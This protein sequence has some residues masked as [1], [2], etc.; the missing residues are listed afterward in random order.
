M[1]LLQRVG[2]I[3]LPLLQRL[4]GT[5]DQPGAS[6]AYRTD[7]DGFVHITPTQSIA[8]GTASDPEQWIAEISRFIDGFSQAVQRDLTQAFTVA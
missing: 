8:W 2:E 1:P 6:E 3:A 7:T 5:R 4:A